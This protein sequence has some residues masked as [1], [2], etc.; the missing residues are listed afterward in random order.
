MTPQPL[1]SD[2]RVFC[3]SMQRTGTTSCGKFFR[4]FGF[5]W[6]GW[7]DDKA[8]GWSQA[9]YEGDYEAIFSSEAFQAANA[10]ED[11]P[12]F[13]PGFFKILYH[14]FPGAKFV[15]FTRDETAWFDSML[16]HSGGDVIGAT[17]VHCKLYRREAEYYDLVARGLL[18]PATQN[19]LQGPKQMKLHG[20]AEHY[21]ALYRLH[22]LE[23]REFFE[24]HAPEALCVL[25]LE[26]ETKW[27][28]LGAFLGVDV[29]S[30]YASHE[31][32]SG[33]GR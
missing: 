30:G 13:A 3:I 25:E 17:Q 20:M 9:W 6:S 14:R 32:R 27:R 5:R 10:Y 33:G 19:R 8:L 4:D 26:D 2:A 28:K 24:R 11:S 29:P 22:T 12:W 15:L 21:K 23:V 31:N 7:P 1:R 16:S 18:D